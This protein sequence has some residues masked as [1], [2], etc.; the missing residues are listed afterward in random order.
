M[1]SKK[2]NKRT[3]AKTSRAVTASPSPSQDAALT[4]FD[5]STVWGDEGLDNDDVIIPKI[6]L[7]QFTSEAVQAGQA[8]PGDF[9]DSMDVEKLLGSVK[10][11]VELIFFGSFKSWWVFHDDEYVQTV[12]M[13]AA[14]KGWEREETGENGEVITRKPLLSFYCVSPTDIAKGEVFPYVLTFKSTSYYT[15][16]KLATYA[17]QL[18][19]KKKPLAAKTFTIGCHK[20]END[21]GK[22]FVMDVNPGR[23][24]TNDE[25]QIA[26]EWYKTLMA[27]QSAGKVKVHEDEEVSSSVAGHSP[28]KDVP[29]N[30]MRI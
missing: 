1:A 4:A 3:T 9:R 21:K 10:N 6:H 25:M 18:R 24:T 17:A 29:Q 15:G 16:K 22:Y 12:P 30:E 13:T 27:A 19:M 8:K 5:G 7:M 11:P 26:H 20:E 23:N 14:N 2:V 28:M